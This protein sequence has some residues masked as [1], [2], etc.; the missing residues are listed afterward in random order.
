MVTNAPPP[1]TYVIGGREWTVE[2]VIRASSHS[3]TLEL[4][5]C[6]S[7]RSM[8]A[9]GAS[10]LQRELET[11]HRIYGVTTGFGENCERDVPRHLVDELPIHLSRFHGCGM[12]RILDPVSARAV[13][14]VRLV[15]LARG[16]SGVRLELLQR[17]CDL[18]NKGVLPCIPEE[19]SVGAS[20]DLTP[21]SYL[22]AL[23]LGEREAWIDGVQLPADEALRRASLEPLELRPK[24]ALALMNGT[25]VMTALACL[26]YGRA[27]VLSRVAALVTALSVTALQSN[28]SHFD[29]TLFAQKPHPGQIEV[30]RWIREACGSTNSTFHRLQDRYSIRCAPHVIGVLEDA[31]PWISTTIEREINSSNDNPLV[32]PVNG[33]VLHGGHFYGGHIAFAMDSLKLLVAHLADLADRQI[34]LLV[35]PAMSN[36]LP[37]NLSGASPE[38]ASLHHG[39]KAIHIATSAFAA[40][41]LH[42][43]MPAGA[44]SRSTES[45]NQDKVSMGTIAARHC[46]RVVELTE[47]TIAGTLLAAV[48]GIRLRIAAGEVRERDLGTTIA[49][50]VESTAEVFP[51][52]VEDRRLDISLHEIV[53][54]IRGD[55]WNLT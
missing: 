46:L 27:R 12:G 4:A 39:F 40:E 13:L 10:L 45:H 28:L 26:A 11:N 21:L 54:M 3:A 48:Q 32:D 23:L 33:Q 53:A 8:V 22:A 9:A 7:W 18:F 50:V 29:E 52:L 2:E 35:N 16:Y 19:G 43:T 49:K 47:Q 20:G 37:A 25:S 38:R 44:F 55:R 36:G 14:I 42:L 34:A 6:P 30:A 31:L 1:S 5:A 17:I 41:A 51:M 15:S 24:E